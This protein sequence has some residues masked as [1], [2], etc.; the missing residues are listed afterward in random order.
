M[1]AKPVLPR[2]QAHR[3]AEAAIDHYRNDGSEKVALELVDDLERAYARISRNPDIG[4][5]R[6]AH[7]LDLP[8]LRF[9]PLTRYPYLVFYIQRDDSIDVWRVLHAQRDIPARMQTQDPSSTT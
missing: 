4:S 8:G 2:E 9:V 7:E 3:D 1:S 6:Y 5:L